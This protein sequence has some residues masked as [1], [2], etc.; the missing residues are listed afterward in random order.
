MWYNDLHLVRIIPRSRLSSVSVCGKVMQGWHQVSKPTCIDGWIS[1]SAVTRLKILLCNFCTNVDWLSEQEVK[2]NVRLVVSVSVYMTT[3][4]LPEDCGWIRGLAVE[5]VC[6]HTWESE[7]CCA[8]ALVHRATIAVVQLFTQVC[9]VIRFWVVRSLSFPCKVE[10]YNRVHKFPRSVNCLLEYS[11][12]MG[13][14]CQISTELSNWCRDHVPPLLGR[15]R[16]FLISSSQRLA[17]NLLPKSTQQKINDQNK[18]LP[19]C[20][21]KLSTH[22]L[23]FY[24]WRQHTAAVVFAL[25]VRDA[26]LEGMS[27][28][29]RCLG[30]AEDVWETEGIW[31]TFQSLWRHL[32]DN[33]KWLFFS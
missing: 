32:G 30:W 25:V 1:S 29:G 23:F 11:L 8:I 31:K 5:G 27:F 16:L 28:F 24:Q 9:L 21:G 6:S 20:C 2:Q 12:A 17:G 33:F 19:L 3:E 7:R 14:T 10:I 22:T 18:T 4:V 13:D 26:R 15:Y